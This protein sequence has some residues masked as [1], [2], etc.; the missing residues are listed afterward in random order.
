MSTDKDNTP[1]LDVI[2]ASK[3]IA[4]GCWR[5]EN[6]ASSGTINRL[7]SAIHTYSGHTGMVWD[8]TGIR[9]LDYISAQFLWEGWSRK[10][11]D[12]AIVPTMLS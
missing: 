3:V 4:R 9:E 5:V 1:R 11:P 7:K 6:L 8:L 12:K 2:D 10:K